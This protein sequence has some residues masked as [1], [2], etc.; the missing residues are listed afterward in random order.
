MLP[1]VT[2]ELPRGTVT[3][4]FTDVEGSTR[5]LHELGAEEYAAALAEHRRVIRDA[6]SAHG[7]VEVDTQGDAFFFAF[8]TAPGARAAAGAL[9]EG[10]ASGPI[11]VRVGL[12]TGT[13]LVTA[14]GYVGDDVHRAARIAACGHGGQ[15]LASATTAA[16]VDGDLHDLGDHRFKDLTAP[17]RVYQLGEADFPPLKTLH[18][19]NLPIPSTPFL[20]R[21]REL[22]EIV[23]LL[24]RE[25]VRLLTLTGPGGTGKTR[26]ALQAAGALSD[27]FP[28]GVWWVPL[29]ALD[30][31]DLVLE[32]ASSQ[33]GAKVD[34][35]AHIAD[36]R[37][38]LLFDNFEHVAA[39]ADGLASL[40]EA[41]PGLELLVTSRAPLHLS[42]EQEY[43]VPPLAHDEAI[44]FFAARASA[45]DPAFEADD[46]TD[47]ICRRLD[48]L[49]LALE[50]A[51]ARVKALSARQ[52]LDRLERRLSLLTGGA[53]DA[54]VRQRTLRATIEWSHDQ[55]TQEE[56]RLFARLAVFAG[57]C[58]LEAA[59]EVCQADLDTL[60]SLVE[61][62]LLRFTNERYWMLETIREY[63][64][65]Q[66]DGSGERASLLERLGQHLV[67][68]AVADGAPLFR[69]KQAEVYTR[70]ELEHPNTR[71]VME[72]ALSERPELASELVA[73]LGDVWST[74]GHLRETRDWIDSVLR[75][76]EAASDRIRAW[77]L[78]HASDV[79]KSVGDVEGAAEA[80]EELV[81]M[82]DNPSI[83][84][85][86]V[87][88][89]LAD[90]S[91][92]ARDRD[93]LRQA[94]EYAERSL[95]FRATHGLPGARAV[96]SLAE[97]ALEEGDLERAE[98]LFERAAGDYA[99][100]GHHHNYTWA[101]LGLGDV[102]RRRGDFRRS[103]ERLREAL[104]IAVR[105]GD[106]AAVGEVL[107]A[108]A[109]LES[110]RA[111]PARAAMLW[112]AGER[113]QDEWGVAVTLR[114]YRDLDVSELPAD[115]LAAGAAMDVDEA[116]AYALSP[117]D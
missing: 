101:L 57:G 72:W 45:S 58:T 87:A 19:T 68:R 90:L 26:L 64:A 97:I 8:P 100:I 44:D 114:R 47:E 110:D 46:A 82:A 94:S 85:L 67:S 59:E 41:C 86:T 55:L 40:L 20:G 73:Y 103:G 77:V 33:L 1:G 21:E 113:L 81:R 31:P 2:R 56:Q 74:R 61:N 29:A 32:S 107:Q 96:N 69:H 93:E 24:S 53:R 16:L 3:F 115:A 88:S 34:L 50:L 92:F 27:R 38:L 25:D 28:H 76:P 15:V 4:L 36:K 48:D 91:D 42:G 14:E 89:A 70:V 104:E 22:E 43:P 10:L 65:E 106:Q 9:V 75:A 30:D 112:G 102:A 71:A 18:Q 62:S 51:A 54:P 13:P 60:Q 117:G 39:A 95:E 66:L 79:R 12:H 49:P 52:I 11:R 83:D 111:R 35:A 63:A 108:F 7:G 98:R 37:M 109:G 84:P 80:C 116:V 99:R 6:C 5:L 78:I 17:E 105:L 23:A